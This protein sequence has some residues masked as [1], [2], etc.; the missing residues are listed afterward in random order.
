MLLQ[1]KS[2]NKYEFGQ[3][4]D[5]LI[6]DKHF[7]LCNSR[8]EPPNAIDKNPI[9]TLRGGIFDETESFDR[10]NFLAKFPFQFV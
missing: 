1:I 7:F 10:R 5:S 3:K 9:S 4:C 6:T 8:N 2:Q